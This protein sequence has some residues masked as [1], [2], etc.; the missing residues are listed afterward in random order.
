MRIT[1][2]GRAVNWKSHVNFEQNH[3]LDLGLHLTAPYEKYPHLK[4]ILEDD[5]LNPKYNVIRSNV[6]FRVPTFMILDNSVGGSTLTE[7]E[8]R[9]QNTFEN[10][11]MLTESTEFVNAEKG[12]Y[13]LR[14]QSSVFTA[15]P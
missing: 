7:K 6:C 13:N 9:D 2:A 10:G 3:A 14:E 8:M 11:C 1:A 12:N 15:L 4:N 5:M